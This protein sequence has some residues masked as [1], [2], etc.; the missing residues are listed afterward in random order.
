M[1]VGRQ[2]R[3]SV[4]VP[5]LFF[6]VK[7]T[8]VLRNF[9]VPVELVK[10]EDA[11]GDVIIADLE[12]DGVMEFE[13]PE[14]LLCFCS[15]VKGRLLNNARKNNITAFTRNHFFKHLPS[16]LERSFIPSERI[17]NFNQLQELFAS[18]EEYLLLDLR[19]KHELDY[20]ML[21][22]AKHL[23][24]S[25]LFMS[26]AQ[27]SAEFRRDNGF[28]KPNKKQLIVLYCK[29]NN[30]SQEIFYKMFKMGY[31]VKMYDGGT[32]EFALHDHAVMRY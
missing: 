9:D 22:G 14:K 10:L 29:T 3:V 30:R 2:V 32:H 31:N 6:Q 5:D 26:L 16:I 17:L 1:A 7:I 25:E 20:G 19:E 24:R 15:H 23:S 27:T 12:A 8:D 4:C 18:K 21:P 13:H 28:D 11:T